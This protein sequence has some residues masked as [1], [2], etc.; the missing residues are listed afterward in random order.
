MC[1]APHVWFLPPHNSPQGEYHYRW[2]EGK[3]REVKELS[4]DHTATM[5]SG[6]GLNI[7]KSRKYN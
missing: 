5:M 4:Q 6:G 3:L 2:A 7:M 1:Q